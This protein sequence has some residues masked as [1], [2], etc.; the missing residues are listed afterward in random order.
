MMKK[1]LLLTI[2]ASILIVITSSLTVNAIWSQYPD[3]VTNSPILRIRT[4]GDYYAM[5]I[6]QA[7]N[8]LFYNQSVWQ[9]I[10]PPSG[11]TN[12]LNLI[13]MDKSTNDKYY[14]YYSNSTANRLE[15]WKYTPSASFSCPSCWSLADSRTQL[16]HSFGYTTPDVF[17]CNQQGYGL[18]GN[19]NDAECYALNGTGNLFNIIGLV[20]GISSSTSG[21]G[22]V[23]YSYLSVDNKYPYIETLVPSTKRIYKF[24]GVSLNLIQSI[25]ESPASYV[26]HYI[27]SF[28]ANQVNAKGYKSEIDTYNISLGQFKSIG[29]NGTAGGMNKVLFSPDGS[30][31]RIFYSTNTD[32]YNTGKILWSISYY[33]NQNPYNLT[34]FSTVELTTASPITDYDFDY[35]LESG[36]LGTNTGTLYQYG[37]PP[38][39]GTYT[40]SAS[41]IPTS[42]LFGTSATFYATPHNQDG[43][44][45]TSITLSIYENQTTPTTVYQ[46]NLIGSPNIPD[47]T[48]VTDT[49]SGTI[50]WNNMKTNH[51]YTVRLVGNDTG[52]H[53]ST[54]TVLN[55]IVISNTTTNTTNYNTTNY[56]QID[57]NITGIQSV[58]SLGENNA[59]ASATNPAHDKIY[60]ISYDSTNPNSI[61]KKVLQINQ[62]TGATVATSLAMGN[63]KIYLGTD[64]EIY[65]FKNAQNA[66]AT[67]LIQNETTTSLN[68][69]S[70]YV[71][72]LT[73]NNDQE[74]WVCNKVW[75]GDQLRYY[76]STDKSTT[77]IGSINPC[78][79]TYLTGELL[80]INM[81]SSGIRIYN[82]TTQTQISS[83]TTDITNS[84][85]G[86]YHDRITTY[87]NIMFAITG[88]N[89]ITKYNLTNPTNP[90]KIA[91]CYSLTGDLVSLEALSENEVIIGTDYPSLRVCDY[92]NNNNLD[93]QTGNYVS[94]LITALTTGNYPY[95][96]SKM[97]DS[98]KFQVAEDKAYAVYF[99]QKS[100]QINPTNQAP[101]VSNVSL[102]TTNPCVGQ[103]IFADINAYDFENN[104]I[105]YDWDC[106]GARPLMA[107]NYYLHSFQCTYSTSGTKI[108]RIWTKDDY[109]LPSQTT[110]NINVTT[111]QQTPNQIQ[112]KIL[113]HETGEPI[114]GATITIDNTYVQLTD[115]FG[116][117]NFIVPNIQ[118]YPV[119]IEKEGYFTGVG[120]ITPSN[121]R[122]TVYLQP[123][124]IGG[125]TVTTLLVNVQDTNS[126]A[127]FESLVTILNPVTGETKYA[128][129]NTQGQAILTNM[130]TGTNLILR[131]SKDGYITEDSYVSISSGEQKTI[132]LTIGTK[133]PSGQTIGNNRGCVDPIEG[134]MLCSPLNISGTGDNCNTDN[135]CITGACLPHPSGIQGKC[136]SFNWSLCDRDGRQRN[137][138]CFASYTTQGIGGGITVWMLGN[139][140]Y[141]LVFVVFLVM[142]AIIMASVRRR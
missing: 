30:G 117:A 57:S 36:W 25:S 8:I 52:N 133:K 11:K 44:P 26:L 106:T 53:I 49:V 137:N 128:N 4:G 15:V 138:A 123:T 110:I 88:T 125:Q 97:G 130:F 28:D 134:V 55:W 127:I 47:G 65:E 93:P 142:F 43:Q 105:Y 118:S 5:A 100:Q 81:G 132:T 35:N 126:N 129:T 9:E 136:A 72:D 33:Y 141:V 86:A 116:N 120:T 58:I 31:G 63:N 23:A 75:T 54:T 121:N 80:I 77:N 99:Y 95:E 16:N 42:T 67:Q 10:N 83:I 34:R 87:N 91:D 61:T 48:I 92:G 90:T 64:N 2:I 119:T 24:N 29:Y 17:A 140:L 78:K 139:F 94:N 39:G 66:D 73:S 27:A 115:T 18:V 59:Y 85:S 68:L 6:T 131:A 113:D 38:Q 51:E 20:D 7:D 108:L 79:T 46:V 82:T 22:V 114:E 60:L 111:C 102:S 14:F 13:S 98:G 84:P 19:V 112:Y 96:I 107:N 37:I 45:T 69:L 124:T 56:E 12:G 74:A 41:V 76:N 32:V 122:V 103:T 104:E 21:S 62:T 135:E 89:K 71:Y 50:F 3:Y 40:I 109:N 70:D 1:N 101:I